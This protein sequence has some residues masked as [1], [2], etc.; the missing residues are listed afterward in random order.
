MKKLS[1]EKM[2]KIEGGWTV[3]GNWSSGLCANFVSFII[4][5]GDPAGTVSKAFWVLCAD[6]AV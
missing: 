1:V 5:T 2:E 3:D 6:N 4:Q